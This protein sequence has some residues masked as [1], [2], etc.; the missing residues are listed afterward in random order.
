[1][2]STNGD[3]E[4]ERWLAEIAREV[5]RLVLDSSVIDHFRGRIR[6]FGQRWNNHVSDLNRASEGRRKH[7]EKV[8]AN[9]EW[10]DKNAG[11]PEGGWEWDR[12]YLGGLNNGPEYYVPAKLLPEYIAALKKQDVRDAIAKLKSE[13][14]DVRTKLN[15]LEHKARHKA[16][17]EVSWGWWRYLGLTDE[18][19]FGCW[20]PPL[21]EI[22]E[23]PVCR[24]MPID[25]T[26]SRQLPPPR[27]KTEEYER[28]CVYLTSIHDNVLTGC[29]RIDNGIWPKQLAEQVWSLFKWKGRY[30]PDTHF[31]EAALERV[32]D[33]LAKPNEV[34][35]MEKRALA[36]EGWAGRS[37]G[38]SRN[39]SGVFAGYSMDMHK[40]VGYV[41]RNEPQM[42][43]PLRDDWET[44]QSLASEID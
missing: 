32:K 36:F 42:A 16:G 41:Q 17:V 20:R 10:Q 28:Y 8:K 3:T 27:D 12:F 7:W 21:E 44:V 2:A 4:Y 35:L 22:A 11:P 31:I 19:L 30:G 14:G 15:E 1:M 37:E 23:D 39:Y 13:L 24:L 33:D 18:Q 34:R 6:P 9:P 43:K 29:E 26:K 5:D 40:I 38:L 25:C